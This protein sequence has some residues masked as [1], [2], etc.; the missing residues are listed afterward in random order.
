MECWF[1]KTLISLHGTFDHHFNSGLNMI[2][3]PLCTDYSR[4]DL[5]PSLLEM[6]DC[7]KCSSCSFCTASMLVSSYQSIIRKYWTNLVNNVC[8]FSYPYMVKYVK[9]VC[10]YMVYYF[11]NISIFVSII[12]LIYII[13]GKFHKWI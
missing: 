2:L 13:L 6:Q 11:R 7:M 8:R 9:V 1:Q 3:S 5:P 4:W 12:L 10:P